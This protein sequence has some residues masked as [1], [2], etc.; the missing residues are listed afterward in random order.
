MCTVLYSV[1]CATKTFRIN[2]YTICNTNMD[3]F[4][5]YTRTL[6]N[7]RWPLWV[8]DELCINVLSMQ[9]CDIFKN[10]HAIIW[11]NH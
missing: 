1:H 4:V 5:L 3:Y 8:K 7:N 11:T 6:G 10:G 2:F 9:R